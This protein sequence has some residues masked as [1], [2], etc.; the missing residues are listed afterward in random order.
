MCEAA[1]TWS[2]NQVTHFFTEGKT[3]GSPKSFAQNC[4]KKTLSQ[5][6]KSLTFDLQHLAP[7]IWTH[8]LTWNDEACSTFAL[9]ITSSVSD[10]ESNICSMTLIVRLEKTLNKHRVS[11]LASIKSFQKR[12]MWQS[13]YLQ[14]RKT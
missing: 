4:S 14:V 7:L 11:K 1:S 3:Y 8:R 10:F 13:H 2:D 5:S 9:R 12:C 6:S